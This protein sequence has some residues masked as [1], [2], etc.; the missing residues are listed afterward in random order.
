MLNLGKY[1]KYL[2]D[3]TLWIHHIMKFW[4]ISHM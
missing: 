2:I 1:Y 3:L 4:H